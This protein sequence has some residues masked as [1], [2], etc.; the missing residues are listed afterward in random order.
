MELAVG[1]H[2]ADRYEVEAHLGRGG[3]G[4][5]YQVRDTATGTACAL[6]VLPRVDAAL[7]QRLLREGRLQGSLDH[8]GVVRVIDVI[9]VDGHPGLV[10]ELVPGGRTL[11]DRLAEG[12]IPHEELEHLAHGL[13]DAVTAAHAHG[14]VHRDLKPANILLDGGQPRVADFG[15]AKALGEQGSVAT[16][17]GALLGTPAYMAPEQ[18]Q[19]PRAVDARADVFSLGAVLYELLSGERAF[20]GAPT[21]AMW[22]AARGEAPPLDP[23]D[24]RAAAVAWALRPTPDDRP[25]DVDALRAAW[26]GALEPPPSAAAAALPPPCPELEELLGRR[27]DPDIVSHLAT[28]APCR[29]DL[30]LYEDFAAAPSARWPVGQWI[31][32][33]LLGTLGALAT[34]TAVMG[35]LG[36]LAAVGPFVVLLLLV[37]G[38]GGTRLAHGVARARE[39]QP[40]SLVGW[41]LAPV[42]VLAVG[43]VATALGTEQA[44]G[45]IDHAQA[46]GSPAA[47]LGALAAQ[48]GH[49]A[50]STWTIGYAIGLVLFALP[51]VA[52]V[53]LARDQS[54][55]PGFDQLPVVMGVGGAAGLWLAEGSG[56]GL[57]AFMATTAVSLL[58]ALLPR[59]ASM[60]RRSVVCLG[61]AVIIG[62]TPI[63]ARVELLRR[64]VLTTE[65]PQEVWTSVVDGWSLAWAALAL[66]VGATA[67]R[68]QPLR[69]LRSIGP[70]G[71]VEVLALIVLAGGP[72]WWTVV[73]MRALGDA[74]LGAG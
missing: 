7:R 44:L 22:K 38:L 10:L 30:R 66:G 48:A 65:A 20:P 4:S 15:L 47:R 41:F 51:V 71:V 59:T 35:G 68:S 56:A 45:A 60:E 25:P 61:A 53:L 43:A 32:G 23:A 64:A 28:C 73:R 72:T 42:L 57:M 50:L 3:M 19:D 46:A 52:L 40:S 36:E 2:I 31:M 69:F 16:A 33:F 67:I 39:G 14:L 34:M 9:D 37:P 55:D 5:V 62:A 17:T 13:F 54:A 74:L 8:P 21:E 26:S 58:V 6:K 12:P 49:V 27:S 70:W 11:A 18:V 63:A 24:P 29:I 1:T